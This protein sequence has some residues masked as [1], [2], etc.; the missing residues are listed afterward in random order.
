MLLFGG[1]RSE[2]S[3]RIEQIAPGPA[4]VIG[5]LPQALSDLTATTIGDTVYVAGG[6]NGTDTNRAILALRPGLSDAGQRRRAAPGRPLPGGRGARRPPD[7]RRR[8]ARLRQSDGRGLGVRPGHR[9]DVAA[10]GAA[11]ADRPRLGRRADGR[12]YLL[13]GL[14][15]GTLSATILSWAPGEPAGASP[16]GSRS[17]S[18]NGGAAPY[19]G[20]VALIGGKTAG[21][22]VA[23][24]T[25]LRPAG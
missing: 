20:G 8:R 25:V 12:F 2:G 18:Q 4:R 6:W 22:T 17:R 11:G 14:R 24:I 15:R 1:G 23:A 19:G 13:G 9:A 5:H 21:G 10:A 7:R 16:G 3:D